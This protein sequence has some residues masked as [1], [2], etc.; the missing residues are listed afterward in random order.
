M[1][2]WIGLGNP[3]SRYAHNRHNAGFMAVE[4][5][6]AAYHAT[7]WSNKFSALCSECLIAGEKIILIKPQNY[8]NRSGQAIGEAMRFYKLT[9]QD[10][11]IF[12]DEL[13]LAFGTL[14][15]K[16]GGGH[17]GH[18]GLRDAD[19]HIGKEYRRIRLGIGRPAEKDYVSDYVLSDFSG[20]EKKEVTLWLEQLAHCA[21]LLVEGKDSEF[22]S[23]IALLSRG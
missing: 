16:T 8:M 12:H 17:G 1:Q 19:A 18:N 5:V 13:D 3:T 7:P 21:P 6:A 10:I 23:K 11:T 9:P 15:V 20:A 2:L 14:R 4:A 22:M